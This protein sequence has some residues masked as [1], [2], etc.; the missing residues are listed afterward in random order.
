MEQKTGRTFQKKTDESQNILDY[1][2]LQ[3]IGRER[4]GRAREKVR[5]WKRETS[6]P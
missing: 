1:Y 2:K 6:Y 3:T 4:K 5:K